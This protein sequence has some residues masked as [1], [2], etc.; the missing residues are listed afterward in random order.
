ME[1]DVKD[2]K[3]CSLVSLNGHI[4]SLTAPQLSRALET[5]ME[6]GIYRIVVDMS[7]VEYMSSAGFRALLAAQRKCRRYNRGEVYLA[8]VPERIREALNLTGLTQLFKTFPDVL[9][10]VGSF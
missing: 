6:R 5:L 3:R 2:F 8:S 7:R 9:Q 1:I 10:A 4:D